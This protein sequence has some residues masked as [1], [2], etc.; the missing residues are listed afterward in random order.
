MNCLLTSHERGYNFSFKDGLLSAVALVSG[1]P[2]AKRH[3][4]LSNRATEPCLGHRIIATLQMIPV[5]GLLFCLIERIAAWSLTRAPLPQAK[6]TA[7]PGVERVSLINA[8]QYDMPGSQPAACTFH[9]VS[10]LREISR[11][12]E[13]ILNWAD[14]RDSAHLSAFQRAVILN[15]GLPL[16]REALARNPELV[17]GAD[18]AQ[19]SPF[20]PPEVQLQQPANHEGLR[21]FAE[22]L[23]EVVG[24]L[25]ALLPATKMVWIKNGN[26]ESFAVVSRG[27]RAII[28]DSHRNEII[29]TTSRNGTEE[30]LREKLL[31]FSTENDGLDITPFS[32]A[33]N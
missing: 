2:Y 17:E 1:A 20:L 11:N 21:S 23:A 12:F 3:W 30:A 19:I 5:F 29:A 28:F 24:H 10:A 15:M 14:Q 13:Q 22:R 27:N 6:P 31:P 9:A 4:E 8:R 7:I 18:F 26:E 32:F 33:T 25:F 16:Y